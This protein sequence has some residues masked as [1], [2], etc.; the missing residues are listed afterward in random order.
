VDPTNPAGVLEGAEEFTLGDGPVGVLLVHG[1]SGTPQAMRPL[2][3]YLADRGLAVEG[4]R[5]PGHGTTWQ[6]LNSHTSKEWTEAVQGGFAKVARGSRKV[7]IVALSFGAAL[8]L[9]FAARRPDDVAGVVTLAGLVYTKDPRRVL[10][11]LIRRLTASVAGVGNDIADA[12]AREIVYDRLPT[13]AAHQMLRFI[14]GARATLPN[15]RCPILVMHSMNDHTVHP[16]NAQVIF[17]TVASQ[18]KEL[19]WLDNGYHVVTLDL[20]KHEVF[21]RT[22]DFITRRADA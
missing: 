14:R 16:G 8:A 13:S 9:D 7:F 1:F 19:V 12:A 5:L 10:A 6:D 18:D 21:E 20:D 3:Q 15:V 11:P 2:G 22:H 17:D 4:I